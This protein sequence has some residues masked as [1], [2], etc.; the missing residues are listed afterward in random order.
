MGPVWLRVL[1]LQR[2]IGDV[3]PAIRAHCIFLKKIVQG[4]EDVAPIWLQVLPLQRCVGDD[5]R[6]SNTRCSLATR[7][8]HA[9]Y[10]TPTTAQ[11][12]MPPPPV[13]LEAGVMCSCAVQWTPHPQR[14]MRTLNYVAKGTAFPGPHRETFMRHLSP[15]W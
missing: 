14:Q 15:A 5:G 11:L 4:Q 1:P 7:V 3:R 10:Q 9:V 13:N 2:C 12:R 6:A 8:L